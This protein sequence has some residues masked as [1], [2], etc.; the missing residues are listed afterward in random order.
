MSK[1]GVDEKG[2]PVDIENSKCTQNPLPGAK[3]RDL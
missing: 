1:N 2:G 3:R